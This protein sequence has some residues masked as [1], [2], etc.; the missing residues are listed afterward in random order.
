[1]GAVAAGCALLL[2]ADAEYIERQQTTTSPQDNSAQTRVALWRGSGALIAD[3]PLGAGGQGFHVLSPQ[4]VPEL[5]DS[6]DGEGRSAHNT[7]IQVAADWGLQGLALFVAFVGYTVVLLHRVRR[8]RHSNDWPYFL[9]LGL[10]LGLIGTLTASFFSVRFY[11][12]SIYWL[13]ALST[14]LYQMTSADVATR[15]LGTSNDANE[16]SAA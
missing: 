13:A 11:G 7:V 6:S 1:V 9:S 8:E 16:Q 5:A 15:S 4:Y 10:E 3:Y 12:E 2:L 14:S